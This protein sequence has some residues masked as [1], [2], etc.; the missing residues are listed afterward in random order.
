MC[1][2]KIM[3]GMKEHR[4]LKCRLLRPKINELLKIIHSIWKCIFVAVNGGRPLI[5][6]IYETVKKLL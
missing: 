4:R 6:E 3:V 2:V 1:A 5:I